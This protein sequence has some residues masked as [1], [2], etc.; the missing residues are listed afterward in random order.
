MRNYFS[1]EFCFSDV[2]VYPGLA[3]VEE[4]GSDG[5]K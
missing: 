1:P 3:M 2:M 5:V 4:L